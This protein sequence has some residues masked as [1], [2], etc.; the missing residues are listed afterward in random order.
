MQTTTVAP[1]RETRWILVLLMALVASFA[2]QMAHATSGY[3]STWRSIYPASNSDQTSCQL[4]HGTSTQN[5]NPYGFDISPN[6]SGWNNI[7]AGINGAAGD[8]SDG[9]SGGYTNLEEINASTQPG[10]TSG[11]IPV[12]NRGSCAPAGTNT[13]DASYDP[14][15]PTAPEICD[16]GID[17]NGNGL[18]DCEEPSCDGFVDGAT[19]CGVGACASTG[20]LVCQSPNQVDS[21]TPGTP[22]AEGP[23]GDPS[24]SDGIDNNCD[25][26]TDGADPDCDAPQET[27]DNGFDDNGNG[28]VD[29]EDPQCN[30]FV[31]GD[32]TCGVGACSASG[33][34]VCQ[35]PNVTDT[36]QPGS[37]GGEGPFGD[38]TC[39]DGIDNDCDG[40]TDAADTDCEELPEICDNG[41]D[42][43]FNGLVDCED[44]QC[45]GFTDGACS[46]G[47][48]GI[49]A[50]GT[51]VCQNGG[52]VCNQ[53]QPAGTEGPFNT[54]TCGD[55]L[56]NDCD[57]LTDANDPDCTPVPEI[58]DDGIDNSGNGL[59]DCADPDCDGF[60]GG[61]CDTGNPGVCSAGTTACR[62]LQEFCDQNQQAIP[63]GPFDSPTCSD[64]LDNDCDGLIDTADPDCAIPPE[65]CDNGSDDNGNG[66]TDCEDPQCDGVTF[67]A[68]DTGIPGICS[69]GILTCDGSAI[70]PV[71]TQDQAAGTE[72]PFDSLTCTDGL[73]NDC[74][75]LTDATDPDCAVPPEVCDNGIDD[76]GDGLVDCADPACDGTVYGPTTCGVGACSASGQTVCQT[77]DIVDTCQPGAP[78]GE[79]PFNDATCS[80]GV[81]ND[82]DGLTDAAD[83][84]CDPVP[85]I[86]DNGVDDNN[87]G[88][89][90]CADPD[91]DGFMDGACDT[92]NAGICAAGTLTCQNGGQACVQDQSA[93]TEGPFGNPTCGDG[94]D[95][96]CDGSTDA[97]D[98]D[99][100]EP[101]LEIC[102]NGIDDSGNG[103]ADCADPACDGFMDGA[104]DT[105][106]AG[107]CAAGTFVCQSGGQACVQDQ[108]AGTEGPFGSPTCQD[109]LD[110]DCDGLTDADDPDCAAPVADVFLSRLQVPNKLNVK[111]GQV[112][113]RKA[114]VRGDGTLLTQDATVTL[115][116][117]GS[118]NVGVVVEPAA[119]TAQVV[120]GNPETQFKFTVFISCNAPGDGTVDWTATISA[121]GNDD[122]ANDVVT[123]TSSVTCR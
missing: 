87:N 67:G 12:W 10:W 123:G 16:N 82:C 121:P 102:D 24:C 107:I 27:C 117:T 85:E 69:A 43:N 66:L 8:N 33:Q 50:D 101:V 103:L 18:V 104:C 9:D 97:A 46:T 70:G 92:G 52:Q 65:V 41:V 118:P 53:N 7:T 22:Q 48:P 119:V 99:C 110:N 32:T 36:C 76:N 5:L 108:S 79:G 23:F 64:G 26:L 57:G 17:D 45:D 120:P 94:L 63:E 14:L 112:V 20:N 68:C 93:G 4:C 38:A 71:C 62:G 55:G 111:P 77:P 88:L 58:C 105:G 11:A 89:V 86:C 84:D 51:N 44:A 30:G 42:D 81:D 113:N 49:C 95:N 47:L 116:G 59:I 54:P 13:A 122:P 72:G 83:P 1:P 2:A 74:D 34:S 19:S 15:D 80:D 75:G 35:T 100:A 39:S 29:C 61:A 109:G 56:D 3:L 78:G 37:P 90:D 31:Y 25:G 114:T 106:N 60:V 40:A 96:D 98:P 6:C 73:D 91:C 28:L 21:C 115:T